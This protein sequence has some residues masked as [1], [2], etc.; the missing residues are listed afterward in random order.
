MSVFVIVRHFDPCKMFVRKAGAC[1]SGAPLQ[2]TTFRITPSLAYYN[3]A[4]M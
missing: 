2:G 1:Q 4:S 3:V